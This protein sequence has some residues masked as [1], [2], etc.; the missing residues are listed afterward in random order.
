MK[1]KNPC[2]IKDEILC[3]SANGIPP[4][5][6]S[7][8]TSDRKWRRI[9]YLVC[10]SIGF[11]D[12]IKRCSWQSSIQH[13]DVLVACWCA[14]H[15]PGVSGYPL[16]ALPCHPCKVCRGWSYIYSLLSYSATDCIQ[17]RR[18]LKFHH[19]CVRSYTSVLYVYILKPWS[20][21]PMQTICG[22]IILLD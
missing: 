1:K 4:S 21:S 12:S 22:R 17:L 3:F 19:F 5:C 15:S 13:A 8:I 10:D 7:Y 18:S 11:P 20:K 14:W 9:E 6:K 16:G 2:E